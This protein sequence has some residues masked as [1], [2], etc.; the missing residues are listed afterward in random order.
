MCIV[1]FL[2][3]LFEH[4]HDKLRS[5]INYW[6]AIELY[7]LLLKVY[8]YYLLSIVSNDDYLCIS[9]FQSGLFLAFWSQLPSEIRFHVKG[10]KLL[11]GQNSTSKIPSLSYQSKTACYGVGFYSLT[12]TN[13]FTLLV[14]QHIQSTSIHIHR[15]FSPLYFITSCY[16]LMIL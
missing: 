1:L 12:A 13:V 2:Q 11:A 14:N 10:I 6:Q 8:Y 4:I 7:K 5:I 15:S 3:P 16:S 9:S